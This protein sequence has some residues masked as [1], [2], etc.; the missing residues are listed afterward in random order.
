VTDLSDIDPA[1]PGEPGELGELGE[2]LRRE[3]G[4]PPAAFRSGLRGRFAG[5]AP[6]PRPENL[7]KLI[8]GY[9]AGG[10]VLLVLGALGAAGAGPFG[11]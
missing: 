2:R 7:R 3:R 6:R 4:R 11:P 9:A 1:A 8:A 10:A 5:R